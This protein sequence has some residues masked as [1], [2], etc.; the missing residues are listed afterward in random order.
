MKLTEEIMEILA[1]YDLTHCYRAAGGLAG[2][3]HH[4]VERYV[5]LRDSGALSA[6]P[7]RR[8]QI[9][10]DHLAKIEQWVD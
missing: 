9:I 10:D 3:S 5:T 7:A 6:E 2:C 4:T 8:A 1:A